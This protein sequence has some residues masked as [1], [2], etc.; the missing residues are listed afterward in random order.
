MSTEHERLGGSTSPGVDGEVQEPKPKFQELEKQVVSIERMGIL[1]QLQTRAIK[2]NDNQSW[3]VWRDFYIDCRH[4]GNANGKLS[5]NHPQRYQAI[6]DFLINENSKSRDGLQ[7]MFNEQF[8]EL[9]SHN[10]NYSEDNEL[11]EFSRASKYRNIAGKRLAEMSEAPLLSSKEEVT[12]AMK[13]ELGKQADDLI[14]QNGNLPSNFRER[15]IFVTEDGQN[16]RDLFAVSNIRLVISIAKK[17]ASRRV[18]L[19]DRVQEGTIGLMVAVD[20]YRYEKGYRFS[21][22]ATP[23]I[24]QT[25]KQAFAKQG[26]IFSLSTYAYDQLRKINWFKEE[27]EKKTGAEPTSTDIS[28]LLGT[29]LGKIEH[30][31]NLSREPISLEE[32]IR[33]GK[34]DENGDNIKDEEASDPHEACEHEDLKAKTQE[35]LSILDARED[36]IL[37]LYYGLGDRNSLSYIEIGIKFGLTPGRIRQI[38]REALDKL[39]ESNGVNLIRNYY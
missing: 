17:Y 12:L 14:K 38:A 15:L 13:I 27:F 2:E 21:T 23:W 19:L 35:T 7:K 37:C 16:A 30:F 22:Y 32:S 25:I 28:R 1:T 9:K 10:I 34:D 6:C 11:E 29:R 26:Y 36:R 20:R 31:S 5:Q 18:Y 8:P 33:K 39:R 24:K 3:Q 4:N